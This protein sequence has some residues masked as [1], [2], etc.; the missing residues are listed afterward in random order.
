MIRATQVRLLLDNGTMHGIVSISEARRMSEEANLDLIEISPNAEPP[1][2]KLMDYGKYKYQE[3]KKLAEAKKKQAVIEVKELKFRPNIEQ[4]DVEV[5]LNKVKE[6]LADGDKIKLIMQFRGREIAYSE[7][8]M[9]RF[10]DII[11]KICEMGA[12]VESDPKMMGNRIIALVSPTK[13]K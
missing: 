11:N 3:Q 4:H 8:G 1:V 5:K 10:K 6:F 7:A 13:K 9:A 12:A 2:V